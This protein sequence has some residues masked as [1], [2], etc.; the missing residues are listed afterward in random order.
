[1]DSYRAEFQIHI[2][3]SIFLFITISVIMVLI[4]NILLGLISAFGSLIYYW[5]DLPPILDP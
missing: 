2:L 4:T 5:I 3:V 1:M